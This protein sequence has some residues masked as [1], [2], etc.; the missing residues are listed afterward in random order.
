MGIRHVDILWCWEER[1]F[2]ADPMILKVVP[3]KYRLFLGVDKEHGEIKERQENK[4]REKIEEMEKT[5]KD[6]SLVP[7]GPLN[8]LL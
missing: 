2:E 8:F 1:V 5:N 6:M 3:P 4:E 7:Y